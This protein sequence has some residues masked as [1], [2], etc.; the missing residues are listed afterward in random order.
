MRTSSPAAFA[1]VLSLATTGCSPTQ[2]IA[3]PGVIN[4]EVEALVRLRAE[5]EA[6]RPLARTDAVREWLDGTASMPIPAERTVWFEPR[7]SAYLPEQ[8]ERLHESER[9]GLRE[10]TAGP[11]R[12]YSTFYGTPLAYLRTL[13]LAADANAM[14]SFDGVRVL[15]FGYGQIGQLRL[16]AQCG[17]EAVGVDNDPVLGVLYSRPGD[18]GRIE[19][20][21]TYATIHGEWPKDARIRARVGEGFDIFIA[22]NV[23]KRGYIHPA[24]PTPDWAR[25]DL[26]MSDEEFL[27]ALSDTLAP[28]GVAVIYN[29][30]GAPRRSDGSYNPAAD[31]ACPW[32]RAQ[33]EDAGFQ[34]LAHDRDESRMAREIG[35]ALGWQDQMDLENALFGTC[36]IVRRPG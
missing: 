35:R 8:Y 18:Q 4:A 11:S 1:C 23:L 21:G 14:A 33:L 6:L 22:R 2:G 12:F 25:V 19:G 9:D 36:T 32:T 34:V 31:I 13:D 26:G 15:D 10:Y 7:T 27:R 16:L 30:G 5:A 20:A 29:L 17:A 28:G 3:D 24:E